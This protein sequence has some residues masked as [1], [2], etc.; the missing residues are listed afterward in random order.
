MTV[1]SIALPGHRV[2]ILRGWYSTAAAAGGTAVIGRGDGPG[3]NWRHGWPAG[4]P[5]GPPAAR[6]VASR[7][8]GCAPGAPARSLVFTRRGW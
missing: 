2:V 4:G 1:S 8:A 5:G 6:V 3:G 7:D